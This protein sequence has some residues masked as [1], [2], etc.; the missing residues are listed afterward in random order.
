MPTRRT[1][2][3]SIAALP[4]FATAAALD[5]TATFKAFGKQALYVPRRDAL[6]IAVQS[7]PTGPPRARSTASGSQ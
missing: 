1:L 6:K 4:S 3:L 5:E 2:L 7:P